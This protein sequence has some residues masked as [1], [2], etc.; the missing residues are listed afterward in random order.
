MKLTNKFAS[1]SAFIAASTF[2]AAIVVSSSMM[3]PETYSGQPPLSV[4]LSVSL[5]IIFHLAMLPVISALNAPDWAKVSGFVWVAVDNL[6]EM[7]SFFGVGGELIIPMRWGIHLAT[8]T[9]LI[10]TS[11]DQK[12]VFRWFG[13]IVAFLLISVT[14]AGPFLERSMVPQTLG[15]AGIPFIIWI[16]TAG[17]RLRKNRS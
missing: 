14:F 4:I 15:L 1:I 13:L 8:A 5:F 17:F 16:F 2:I 12:G 7:M 9:W 10:G 6:L 11:L 3:P